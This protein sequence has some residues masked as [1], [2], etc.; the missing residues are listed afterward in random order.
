MAKIPTLNEWT[1]ASEYLINLRCTVVNDIQPLLS[2]EGA[3]PFAI[4]REV[5]CYIDHLAHLYTGRVDV[6]NRFSIFLNDVASKVDNNYRSRS[7]EI[8]RM[9]R[10][11]TVHEF[12]PKTLENNKGDLLYW[13]C[14]PGERTGSLKIEETKCVVKHLVP[15]GE[16]GKYWL[17]V[18]T[19]CFIEDLI[20]FIN[21]F[22][23]AGPKDERKTLW[24]R[25]A[26]DLNTKVPYDF[27]V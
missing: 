6:G 19:K 18:S 14:Y 17:P 21:R 22:I 5:L 27:K 15:Y 23:S 11:G 1:E 24:N 4:S 7:E 10:N 26:R 16:N 25:A 13:L 8:Y 9:Y 12:E 20:E 3:A 2:A